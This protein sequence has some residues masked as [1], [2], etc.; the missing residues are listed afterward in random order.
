VG[1]KSIVLVAL[2]AVFVF[3]FLSI[4]KQGVEYF[5]GG[6]LDLM[7]NEGEL[8]E[9]GMRS[10]EECNI[11]DYQADEYSPLTQY[12]FCRYMLEEL[13][14]TEVIVQV[15]TFSN[16]HD[17]DGA[18]QYDSTHLFSQE[19]LIGED[20]FGDKSRLRVNHEK[21]Y[22]GQ[23]NDPDI[24]YYHLWICKNEYLIHITSKGSRE[25]KVYIGRM[26]EVILSKIS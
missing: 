2:L 14:D 21:D 19:G 4:P 6:I 17:R 26:G 10:D 16:L 15:K 8:Q 7:L 24:T 18:Y 9:L 5:S 23:F 25:A 1:R 12:S 11:E 13:D 22:G 3:V 20:E